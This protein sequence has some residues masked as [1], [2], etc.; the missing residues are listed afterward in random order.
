M[1]SVL[2]SYRSAVTPAIGL[3]RNGASMRTTKRPPTASPEPVREATSDAEAMRLNQSPKRLT[4]CPYQRFR[5]SAFPRNLDNR[6][7][8]SWRTRDSK[9]G[10]TQRRKGE[11]PIQGD[12][13]SGVGRWGD[14]RSFAVSLFYALLLPSCSSRNSVPGARRRRRLLVDPRA[15]SGS[16]SLSKSFAS[17]SWSLAVGGIESDRP[18][19]VLPSGFGAAGVLGEPASEHA[20]I[21]RLVGLSRTASLMESDGVEVIPACQWRLAS[22][23]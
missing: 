10:R 14:S 4:T 17:S 5:K 21:V 12:R 16:P 18:F 23:K 8:R 9:P 7:S 1:R 3:T 22:R 19:E 11:E 15:F 6:R 2:L 13:G 20:M